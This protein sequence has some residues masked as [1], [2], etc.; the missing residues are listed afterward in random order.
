MSEPV[1]MSV[2]V[3]VYNRR[4]LIRRCL[5]SVLRQTFKDFELIVVDDGSDD[6]SEKICDKYCE[7]YSAVRVLH[8][9]NRGVSRA[10]NAGI[11]NAKGRIC[12][13]VDSDDS[14][15]P[16]YLMN[17]AKAFEKYGEE[18]VYISSYKIKTDQDIR[19]LQYEKNH[20]YS[21]SDG[22]NFFQL[23]GKGLFNAIN[24][25]LYLLQLVREYK[26]RFPEKYDYG[27]DLIFNLRYFDKTAFRFLVL[28]HNFYW[29]Y[30]VKKGDSLECK[31]R[32][33]YIEIQRRLLRTKIRYID[34]WEKEGKISQEENRYKAIVYFSFVNENIDYHIKHTIKG[35]LNIVGLYNKLKELKS[36]PE[37]A[38]CVQIN[39]G[40]GLNKMILQRFFLYLKQ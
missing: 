8:Q 37:Y 19:Y 39:N 7:M 10:R 26:I 6:G 18:Y 5:D 27:E 17:F 32:E 38:K 30:G 3:P 16:N 34:K 11:D 40:Q 23:I 2:I 31:W 20:P 1:L 9:R 21:A 13:F 25:K 15:P 24:N 29:Y 12:V 4:G 36:L 35:N 22:S 14:I 28:N 33:D